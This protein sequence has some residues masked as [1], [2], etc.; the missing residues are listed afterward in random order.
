M[1][2]DIIFGKAKLGDAEAISQLIGLFAK[3]GKLSERAL[4]D[5]QKS[6]RDFFIAKKED[7][8]VGCIAVA[9]SHGI[10]EFK[11]LAVDK[12][13]QGKGIGSRLVELALYE[14]KIFGAKTA[15]AMTSVGK[16]LE[17]SRFRPATEEEL[18]SI[19]PEMMKCHEPCIP[20]V[21]DLRHI[22]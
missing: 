22:E 18:K 1:Q 17:K 3:E 7:K 2:S 6:V 10:A 16:L 21:N 11:S 5:I 20:M 4:P 15:F 14:S 8:L 13:F 19:P 12:E 9:F